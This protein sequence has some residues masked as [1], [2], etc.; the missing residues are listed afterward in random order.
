MIVLRTNLHPGAQRNLWLCQDL[1]YLLI[2][3]LGTW[4]TICIGFK[5]LYEDDLMDCA[6]PSVPILTLAGL[7]IT[8]RSLWMNN[9]IRLYFGVLKISLYSTGLEGICATLKLHIQALKL[10]IYHYVAIYLKY[11]ILALSWG[12]RK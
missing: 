9:C 4:G 1:A 11:V 5:R 3:C 2:D 10:Y 8:L 6:I 12:A 7:M